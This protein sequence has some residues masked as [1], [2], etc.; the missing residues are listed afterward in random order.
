[1]RRPTSALLKTHY[2]GG[3][4]KYQWATM[5]L[6][7]HGVFTRADGTTVTVQV[8]ED[9]GRPRLLHPDLLPHLS[10]EQNKRELSD[11]IRGEE[12]NILIGSEA[13]E[14]EEVKEKVKLQTM[15]LLNEKY[16]ITEK[17]FTRAELEIVP[18]TTRPRHRL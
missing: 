14:D 5:P 11:G 7:I 10:A 12:L 9:L 17:D 16:G 13:V 6:A 2:Y 15:I 1:M 4:R 8:G 3:I 18:A